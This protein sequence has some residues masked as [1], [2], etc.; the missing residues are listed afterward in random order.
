MSET[1]CDSLAPRPLPLATPV[2]E[3]EQWDLIIRPKRHLLDVNLQEIWDYRDL[4]Y[5]FVKRDIVTVYQ[6]TILGPIWFFVQPIATMLTYVIVFGRI[7]NISTDGVPAPMFYLSGVII[8]NYFQDCLLK[9]SGTFVSNAGIFGKVYFPRL[10]V[11]LSQVIS[12]VIKFLI[13]FLLFLALWVWYLINADALHPN[14]WLLSTVYCL[15]LMAGMGLGLGIIFSSLTTKYRDLNFLLAFGVQL[16]M[17]ATP[18]IYPMSVLSENMRWYLWWNP[19]S[20]VMEAFK[21]GFLGSGSAS[22]AGLAYTTG[23]TVITLILGV[24][25]FNRTEQTFMDTV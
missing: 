11:P 2:D 4:L 20:H 3:A 7:A 6:Q 1:I 21:Y 17:Y 22:I 8:W 10:I 24:I 9:T 23:F 16:L 15:L 14:L 12:G 13:Q 19:I 5:M 25:I 18:I